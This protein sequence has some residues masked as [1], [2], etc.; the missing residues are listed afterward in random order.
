MSTNQM[1]KATTRDQDGPT[2]HESYASMVS[3]SGF[4]IKNVLCT[5]TAE[6]IS[7]RVTWKTTPENPILTQHS[8]LPYISMFG[9]NSD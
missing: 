2:A 9:T 6:L 1:V 4:Q 3:G 5:H 8:F 7:K